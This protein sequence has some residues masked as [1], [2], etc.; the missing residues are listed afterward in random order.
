MGLRGLFK[1]VGGMMMLAVTSFYLFSLNLALMALLIQYAI[2]RKVEKLSRVAGTR[3]AD[4]SA[5]AGE[6]LIHVQPFS[7]SRRKRQEVTRSGRTEI[8]FVT[9]VVRT[10]DRLAD[11][12]DRRRRHGHDHI[13]AGSAPPGARQPVAGGELASFVLYASLGGG[14][15]RHHGGSLGRCGARRGD[16]AA[17]RTVPCR[18]SAVARAKL[19]PSGKCHCLSAPAAIS[20]ERVISYRHATKPRP[21]R[22]AR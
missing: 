16:R 18:N 21:G 9:A 2:G 13:G 6:I 20:F 17:A 3:I 15:R 10:I 19:Q 8:S 22:R 14:R 4:A 12:A 5:L 7:L 11:G 1:F